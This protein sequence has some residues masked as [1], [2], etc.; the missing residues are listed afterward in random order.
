MF[1]TSYSKMPK[2]FVIDYYFYFILSEKRNFLSNI[3]L[4][5][6]LHLN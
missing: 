1:T 3:F 5:K 4:K 2:T 6:D